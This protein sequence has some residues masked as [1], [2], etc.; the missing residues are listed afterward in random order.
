[1]PFAIRHLPNTREDLLEFPGPG[2]LVRYG[3]DANDCGALKLQ[4]DTGHGTRMRLSQLRI[5]PVQLD[6]V[7]FT[8]MHNDHIEGF[9]DLVAQRWM[10][11]GE[12]PKLDAICSSDVTSSLGVTRSG[13]TIS[14]GAISGIST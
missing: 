7:F 1:M 2:T 6:A 5:D 10:F 8:H 11:N 4:F 12:G 3:D 13:S 14:D 9:A